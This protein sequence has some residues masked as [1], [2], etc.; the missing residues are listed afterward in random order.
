[1]NGNTDTGA[2]PVQLY[3]EIRRLLNAADP[4]LRRLLSSALQAGT[5]SIAPPVQ[6]YRL[7]EGARRLSISRSH[8]YRLEAEGL[9]KFTRVG[10]S[11]RISEAEL[12]RVER[13][14]A[15]IERQRPAARMA[16]A[17]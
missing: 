17:G 8:L 9:I 10:A 11:V 16:A 6:L 4:D 3:R 5:D 15:A 12:Q 13:G 7:D 2:Q 1:M 14:K